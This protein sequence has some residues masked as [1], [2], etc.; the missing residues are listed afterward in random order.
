VCEQALKIIPA[1]GA[2][3]QMRRDVRIPLLRLGAVDGNQLCVDVQQLH[4]LI[5]SRVA[6]V[7][8]QEA[9]ERLPAVHKSPVGCW[10]RY[11]LAI[12][13]ARSLRRVSNSVL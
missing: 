13:L 4:R 2:R 9:I 6:R 5:A 10:S 7:G 8:L 11:P 12:R 1:R 3:A